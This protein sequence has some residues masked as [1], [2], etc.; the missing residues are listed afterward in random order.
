MIGTV[1][2]KGVRRSRD[3]YQDLSLVCVARVLHNQ[4]GYVVDDV[5][6]RD[7]GCDGDVKEDPDESWFAVSRLLPGDT[8]GQ[9]YVNGA[10]VFHDDDLFVFDEEG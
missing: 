9:F 5:P 10:D 7:F 3:N 6:Y 4:H 8:Y 2:F 1:H